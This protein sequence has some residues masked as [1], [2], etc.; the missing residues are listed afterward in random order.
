MDRAELYRVLKEYTPAEMAVRNGNP[1]NTVKC[2]TRN[3]DTIQLCMNEFI[4]PGENIGIH[5]QDRFAGV[6]AHTH[7]YIELAYVWSGSCIQEIEGQKQRSMEGDV[8]IFDTQAVHSFGYTG[9][10]DIVINILM[11]REFFD[12]AFL[13]R[14]SG[15]GVLSEF[16][17]DSVTKSRK[18]RHYLYFHTHENQAVRRIMEQIL[19]EYYNR[20]LGNGQV[21]ESYLVILF[22]ELLRSMRDV[23][24]TENERERNDICELLAYIEQNYE[25][26]TLTDLAE[27]FGFNGNYL[28]GL[29]KERTGRSFLEHVQEQKLKKACALLKN[30]DLSVQEIVPLCGYANLNFFYK[31]FKEAEGC[32]P[33]QYRKQVSGRT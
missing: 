19:L 17:V 27:H 10:D 13:T 26:C 31:K 28:T 9:E 21:M 18:K 5:R 25:R 3:P 6:A 7:D 2:P 29:L 15:Q 1:G 33:A 12:A 4:S 16:L 32:T 20:D 11:R 24:K 8:C 14:I 30:T 23:T 22:V